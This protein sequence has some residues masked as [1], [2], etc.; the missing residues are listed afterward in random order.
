MLLR[1]EVGLKSH[2]RDVVGERVARKIKGELALT[3]A[4]VGIV[5]VYTVEGIDQAQAE[6]VLAAGALHDPVLHEISLAP[7]APA[8]TGAFDW[9]LEVGFRPGV[10]DNEART[11]KETIALV[12]GLS[13]AAAQNLS[14]YTSVQYLLRAQAGEALDE[15]TVLHIARDLLANELIQRFEL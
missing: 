6:A 11:A 7:L 15:K 9:A 10:T 8:Q 3:L 4:G 2:V 12:L 13:K 5:R 14:V 1:F